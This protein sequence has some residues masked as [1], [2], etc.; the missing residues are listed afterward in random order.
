MVKTFFDQP[1]KS[2]L[3]TYENVRKIPTCK[4]DDYTNGCFLD[5]CYFKQKLQNNCDKF[6]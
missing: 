3:K 5:H 2:E 6:K 1:I 4:G